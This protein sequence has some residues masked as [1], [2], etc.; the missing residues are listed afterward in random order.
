[1]AVSQIYLRY[2]HGVRL[3]EIKTVKDA[4]KRFFQPFLLVEVSQVTCD[5]RWGKNE[6]CL[7]KPIYNTAKPFSDA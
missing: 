2:C 7:G 3:K 4:A 5:M 1:V 6:S